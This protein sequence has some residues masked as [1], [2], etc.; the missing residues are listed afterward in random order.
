MLKYPLTKIRVYIVSV[1]SM[2]SFIGIL[3]GIPVQ[4][5]RKIYRLAE[6]PVL[7]CCSS[8]LLWYTDPTAMGGGGEGSHPSSSSGEAWKTKGNFPMIFAFWEGKV[9][10]WS[11]GLRVFCTPG[12]EEV[13]LVGGA[14]QYLSV[15]FK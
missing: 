4:V 13:D 14:P 7:W 9:V 8:S 1:D 2:I 3:R 10:D 15:F 11:S 6:I 12:T 5:I